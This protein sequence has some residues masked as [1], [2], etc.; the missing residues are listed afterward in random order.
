MCGVYIYI[1]IYII[2]KILIEYMQ[3]IYNRYIYIY[4][5]YIYIYIE[6]IYIYIEYVDFDRI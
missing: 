2:C 6:H 1:N 4:L 3:Y 5:T